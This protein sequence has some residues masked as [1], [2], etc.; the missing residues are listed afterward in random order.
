MY[1]S[2]PA[3]RQ[4]LAD[5]LTAMGYVPTQAQSCFD[6]GKID[7][8]CQE[9]RR[10]TFD[11]HRSSLQP[12]ILGPCKEILGGHHRVVA[13]HLAGVDLARSNGGPPQ[14]YTLGQSYR[15]AR[16]WI[17]VLPDVR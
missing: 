17:D 15:A 3:G 14:V 4:S 9:M 13:A 8:M 16:A 2:T 10:G 5:E 11:W 12:I 7:A 1:P 6:R